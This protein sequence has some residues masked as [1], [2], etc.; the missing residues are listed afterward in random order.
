MTQG[1]GVQHNESIT[2]I[3]SQTIKQWV[4]MVKECGFKTRDRV[5]LRN[6]VFTNKTPV[7]LGLG[8]KHGVVRTWHTKGFSRQCPFGFSMR[9]KM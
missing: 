2:G 1:F 9:K 4:N 5:D 6:V 8:H 3:S 7:A